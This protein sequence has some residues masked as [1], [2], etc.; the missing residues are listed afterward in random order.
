M[1]EE[2]KLHALFTMMEEENTKHTEVD[3]LNAAKQ[4]RQKNTGEKQ[5]AII[6]SEDFAGN[7]IYVDYEGNICSTK[8]KESPLLI[9]GT[10]ISRHGSNITFEG[11]ISLTTRKSALVLRYKESPYQYAHMVDFEFDIDA[12]DAFHALNAYLRKITEE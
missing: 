10:W 11:K 7:V 5:R 12:Q 6:L 9:K 8:G 3:G 2:L 1:E 4:E